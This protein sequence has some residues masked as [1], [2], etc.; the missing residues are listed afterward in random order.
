MKVNI[1]LYENCTVAK[2]VSG[3]ASKSLFL[4]LYIQV[5]CMTKDMVY[6]LNFG[7]KLTAQQKHGCGVKMVLCV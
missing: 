3:A 6:Y 1:D 7:I 2:R 5:Q 4:S